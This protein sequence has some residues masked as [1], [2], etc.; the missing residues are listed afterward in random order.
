MTQKSTFCQILS[1]K[2]YKVSD[3]D[4]W[5]S[6]SVQFW[7]E[8]FKK[9]QFLEKV[10]VKSSRGS[11]LFRKIDI[12]CPI[13]AFLKE[14]FWKKTKCNVSSLSWKKSQLV[15][16]WIK[17]FTTCHNLNWKFPNVSDFDLKI[18]R[19]V[20]IWLRI[21]EK[22]QALKWKYTMCQIL[23]EKFYYKLKFELRFL[24]RVRLLT[25]KFTTCQVLTQNFHQVSHFESKISQHFKFC[26]KKVTTGHF[27]N[28]KFYNV[29]DFASKVWPLV[30]FWVG[31]IT[32][33]QALS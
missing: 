33:L 6:K 27:L 24:H 11:F 23:I 22:F 21:I 5:N 1:Q 16:F 32:L 19:R 25:E 26:M 2:F 17:S 29:S 4:W 30:R 28:Y 10:A 31:I 14:L 3:F 20:I 15:R 8:N 12:F 9:W 7:V 18:L 13:P